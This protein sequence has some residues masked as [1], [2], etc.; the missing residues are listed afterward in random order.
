ME[1]KYL[2]DLSPSILGKSPLNT[3]YNQPGCPKEL[4]SE[5]TYEIPS[6]QP[7]KEDTK[8]S[9]GNKKAPKKA[10]KRKATEALPTT[11]AKIKKTEI[12][13]RKRKLTEHLKKKTCP[14]TLRYSARATI[15]ADEDF[16]KG[17]KTIK[18]KAEQGFIRAL[19][20]FHYRRLEKQKIKL[21]KDKAK[22]RRLSESGSKCNKSS[23]TQPTAVSRSVKLKKL[24]ELKAKVDQMELELT[25]Q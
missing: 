2:S 9:S 18:E 19:T 13:I 5:D 12:S 22:A 20:R 7:P 24:E 4:Q 15:L 16:K 3:S 25:R 23:A 6:F 1:D 14:K 17:I 8:P 21:N 10:D 11:E